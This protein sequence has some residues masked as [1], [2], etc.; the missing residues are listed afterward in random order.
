MPP[1]TDQAE[2]TDSHSN[3]SPIISVLYVDD[4][5]GLLMLGKLYLERGG[6]YR[7][8]TLS[9]AKEALNS[10]HLN[11]YD[12][13]I[14]DYQMPGMDGIE[15]LKQ[16]R[17]SGST[18][19]FILFTGRGREEVVI[20]AINHGA[21]FYLQKGGEPQAQFAEL[22]HKIRQA[23]ARRQAERSLIESEKR[24]SDIINFLPDATFAINRDGFIIAWNRAIEEMTGWS[25]EQMLGKGNFEYAL[26][27]YGERRK[28]LID[29]IFEPDEVVSQRYSQIVRENDILIAQSSLPRPRNQTVSL[30]GKASPLYNSSGE[31]VG[32]IESIRDISDLKKA[33][34]ELRKQV[35]LLVE[36]EQRVKKSEENYRDLFDNSVVGIFRTTLDGKFSAINTTFARISGYATP[37]EMMGEVTDVRHQL[38]VH[39]DDRDRFMSALMKDGFVKGFVAQYHHH[40]GYPVWIMINA[41]AV[42]DHHGAIQYFEGTI[43]DIS[44][45]KRAEDALLQERI[46]LDSFI[47]S[48][49]GIHYLYDAEGRLQRWN[50][51]IEILTG[52][53]AEELAGKHILDWFRHDTGAERVVSNGLKAASRDGQATLEA[54]LET[55]NHQKIPLFLTIRRLDINNQIYFTGVG[56]DISER[57]K[58]ED[59][60]HEALEQITLREEELKQQ[61]D[62][63]ARSEK[64]IRDSE[65]KF[66]AVFE[67]SHNALMIIEDGRL[68]DINEKALRLFGYDTLE[69]MADLK[70]SDTS[71]EFQPD[72]QD[73]DTAIGIHI[74]EAFEHGGEQFEWVHKRKDGSTFTAGIF[75]STFE[76]NGRQY[77][78]S[79]ILDITDRKLSETA[80][81][82]SE[83]KY[84]HVIQFSP[85]GMHFYELHSNG[86]LIFTGANPAAD[87]ILGVDHS[88]FIGKT[89]EDAFPGLVGTAIP[90]QYRRIATEGGIWHTDQ[91]FYDSEEIRGAY[92]VQAFQ[93]QPGMMAAS[94]FDITERKRSEEALQRSEKR[95]RESQEMAHLGFWSWDIKTGVVEWSEELY[96]IFGRNPKEFSPTIDSVLALSPWPE[97]SQRGEELIRKA[98]G[99]RGKGTFVQRFLRP[100]SSI[101][102]YLSTYEGRYDDKGDL[103]SIIGTALDITDRKLAEEALKESEEKYRT[104]FK[105]SNDAIFF[106]DITTRR[107]VDCNRKAEILTGYSREEILSMSA[108]D[109]HP[110][111][112]REQTMDSFQT[113]ID[114]NTS[115][116]ESFIQ[117]RDGKVISVSINAGTPTGI[118]G[119]TIIMGI[120]RDITWQ[121]E[122]ENTIRKKTEEVD[123]FFNVS[124][125]LFC[126]ADIQGYFH[127]LNPEWEKT[128]GYT[129]PE[130]EGKQFFD[131]VH[132]D[133]MNATLDSLS[134]LQDQKEVLS[135]VNRYRHKNGTYRWI[136]WR[137]FPVGD[138]IF[139]AARDIT[140]RYVNEQY[141]A[142]LNTLKQ[143]LLRFGSL[144]EKLRKIT[145]IC[146][147]LFGA[148]SAIIWITGPGD[149]CDQGCSYARGE[150]GSSICHDRTEC[151]HQVVYSG[152]NTRIPGNHRRIP[153]NDSVIG[154]M[155]AGTDTHIIIPDLTGHPEICD[156]AWVTS[157]GTISFAGF[158]LLSSDGLP[159]GV[160]ALFSREEITRDSTGYMGDL[161]TTT[162]QVI[163][164]VAADDA[165]RESEEKF[166]QLITLTPLALCLVNKDG[167][168]EYSNNRFI[169]IFGYTQE[170]MPT[171][172]DWWSL[173]YPDE[174]Y[175]A[176]V[177][178]NWTDSVN[179]AL[180]THHDIDPAEFTVTCK[181][182]T[183]RNVIIGGITIEDKYL[184]TLTDVTD[185]RVAEK[186]LRESEERYRNIIEN[187]QDVFFRIDKENRIAMASPS[188]ARVFRYGSIDEMIGMDVLAIWKR[189]E[190]RAIF[191]ETM[192]QQDGAVQGYETEF[193]KK[194]GTSFW[195]SMSG[196]LITDEQGNYA[197]TEGF[198]H[199]ITER[200]KAEAAVLIANKKLNLL[201]GI[202]RHDINNQLNALQG[203]L[204]ISRDFL[205]DPIRMADF[206]EKEEKVTKTI[207]RQI[208]FTRD[209]EDMG[210]IS[211]SWQDIRTMVN[212]V[213][214]KLPMQD[215]K[216]RIPDRNAEIY[217]DPLLE[218]VFYN[219]IDNSLRYGGERMKE[220]HITYRS[221]GNHEVIRFQD[222]GKGVPADEKEQIFSKGY[223]QN[224]GLGLFLSREI[225]AITG[226]TIIENGVPGSG[227]Q[228][229]IHVP[230]EGFRYRS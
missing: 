103:V 154:N 131:F 215:V 60:L 173:A 78:Q 152:R 147:Q 148:E 3:T 42:R 65:V 88:G 211:P 116:I 1:H 47:N 31:I 108:S 175:R 171:L 96:Q 158:R 162:S 20:E 182:G 127:R 166:R 137:S 185:R 30:M 15:F 198:L 161:A 121:K 44:E 62:L 83:E 22:A 85:F 89:I 101:G 226:I 67:K 79:S 176:W 10:P 27:F 25:S 48:I 169:Q 207:T 189:A 188:A 132:P 92:E 220:I 71:P 117:T 174:H 179:Q 63:L 111:D 55:K 77:L 157:H 190:D 141:M 210:V 216:I 129:L 187:I 106:A 192:K 87:R 164:M 75:L 46:F 194:D 214:A 69:E 109:L 7:I 168:I 86:D 200:K 124:L 206:I 170:D 58:I 21:D 138:R 202:T 14:S 139:A 100:D 2:D 204:E 155:I 230:K 133:D 222:D 84:R 17:S 191:L 54:L 12:A 218:K 13:I 199:D 95:L 18:I 196:H 119:R 23:V 201:S 146:V 91:T 163:Q 172:K 197:G 126:I 165:L 219:L 37:E 144:E 16:I 149:R 40:D 145:D 208:L 53:D 35:D 6:T 195:V 73:S 140:R 184:A 34:E 181:D 120:F 52:Y 203:F 8:D 93:I 205:S 217:A 4:E 223:G 94:F 209:Y 41:N 33:E 112:I 45:Q 72:G 43:E 98:T 193:V 82:K 50:K 66:R 74:Q 115:S 36:S 227:A 38:Y 135:F 56:I 130:L 29:L 110:P 99:S 39:E 212:D 228:F 167:S 68:V 9:S 156:P 24:L 64:Q 134:D 224:S 61:L 5:E 180:Q 143:D 221:E 213:I 26:P 159:I 229:E 90:D 177:V 97:E 51:N 81:L 113:F 32:A 57:K 160:L 114:G 186:A 49:P 70:S 151:L 123:L 105:E 128:L 80:L 28:I 122:V 183:V 125:D 178:K 150:G 136:E 102:Y 153:L 225:L 142:G 107:L 118:G 11:S 104:L 19:P 76:N 59:E